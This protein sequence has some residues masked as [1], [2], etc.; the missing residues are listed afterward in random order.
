MNNLII[1]Q[2]AEQM[3]NEKSPLNYSLLSNVQKITSA[4]IGHIF[5]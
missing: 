3:K 1:E 5:Y 2:G 4:E